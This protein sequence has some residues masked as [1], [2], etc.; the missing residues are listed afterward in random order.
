MSQR[1]WAATGVACSSIAVIAMLAAISCRSRAEAPAALRLTA[2]YT[3][4][5]IAAPAPAPASGLGTLLPLKGWE[6]GLGVADLRIVD[7]K[8][9]GRS[10][11]D[12]PVIHLDW[13][14]MPSSADTVHAIVL[15]LKV[16]AGSAVALG[17]SA[18]AKGFDLKKRSRSRRRGRGA[19]PRGS[20]RRGPPYGRDRPPLTRPARALASHHDPAD[21]RRRR[22]VRHRVD[23]H[24]VSRRLSEAS[25]RA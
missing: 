19:R 24:R 22:V 18:D 17:F 1:S 9:T 16:S 12:T 11:S 13:A 15:K 3:P 20:S 2:L 5:A 23:P 10:T 7:G 21:G 8:L 6:A 4:A 14:D 25:G